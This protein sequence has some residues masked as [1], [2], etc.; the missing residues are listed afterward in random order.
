MIEFVGVIFVAVIFSAL[1]WAVFLFVL[2]PFLMGE[3]APATA[4]ALHEFFVG[5]RAR[6][7]HPYRFAAASSLLLTIS[8]TNLGPVGAEYVL[9]EFTSNE[10]AAS[11][12]LIQRGKVQ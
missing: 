2:S 4:H 12:A 7:E 11:T 8:S 3:N 6:L 5:P 10:I 1:F 9:I